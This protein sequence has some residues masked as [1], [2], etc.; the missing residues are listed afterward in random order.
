[1]RNGGTLDTGFRTPQQIK[2]EGEKVR[3]SAF[4]QKGSTVETNVNSDLMADYRDKLI[5]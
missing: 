3:K 5:A 4:D 1:M 2:E